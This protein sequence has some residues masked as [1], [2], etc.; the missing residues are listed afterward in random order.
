[1]S[2]A[3]SLTI[4]TQSRLRTMRTCLRQAFYRYELGL[5]R[6]RTADALRLGTAF[7]LGMQRLNEGRSI[8]DT[9]AEIAAGYS[10]VPEWAD[11]QAWEVERE[12]AAA[13]IVGHRWRYEQDEFEVVAAE[14]PFA[15]PLVNPESGRASR[16]YTLAGKIDAIIRMPDGRHAVL[17]YKTCGED[18]G[19]DSDYWPRLNCDPQVSMY[20]LAAR[21]LGY[22]TA[23][24][25][26]DV[27]R[28]PSIA[29][30]QIP[31]LDDSGDK[32]VLDANGDRVLTKQGRP[33][34]TGDAALG[35]VLQTRVE[36]PTE[37]GDRLMRDMGERPEFY[38]ARREVVRLESDLDDFRHEL[39]QQARHH[40]EC[41][42]HGRWF[43]NVSQMTCNHCEYS[44]LCLYGVSVDPDAPPSG[45][46][47]LTNVHPELGDA[48]VNR[49]EQT[50]APAAE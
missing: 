41:L 17:E 44:S 8:E 30:R 42:R 14:L 7:H 13:M 40:A 34:Q 27:S 4:L 50:S 21:H 48:N 1:M 6:V 37:F 22:D 32:I 43:R 2:D 47:R 35:Y 36:T 29:P 28:K 39:W 49:T 31:I 11:A 19:P 38:F 5:S 45:F 20:V 9:I 26:Y 3:T 25:L 15:M 18:I 33:R 12:T 46:V 23:T 24:V 10:A 16:S